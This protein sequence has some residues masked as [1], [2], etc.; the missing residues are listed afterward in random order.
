MVTIKKLEECKQN[1][2][3]IRLYDYNNQEKSDM[4]EK[5]GN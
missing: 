2:Q 1:I 5:V 4:E 3:C